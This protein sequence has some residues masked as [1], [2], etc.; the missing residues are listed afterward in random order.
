MAEQGSK[1]PG[2]VYSGSADLVK[3]RRKFPGQLSVTD[4][5]LFWIPSSY[6]KRHGLEQIYGWNS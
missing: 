6:S 2:A 3:N 1:R 4:S 5:G